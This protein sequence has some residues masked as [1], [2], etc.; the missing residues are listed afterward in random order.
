[1]ILHRASSR[2]CFPSSLLL[3][4]PTAP[5]PCLSSSLLR[6]LHRPHALTP[7]HNPTLDRLTLLSLL[8]ELCTLL[9]PTQFHRVAR[10]PS[11]PPSREAE[12]GTV[13]D[14][15]VT[16]ELVEEFRVPQDRSRKQ[17]IEVG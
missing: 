12:L 9:H 4:V 8:L 15:G 2:S 17:V 14:G 3:V 6:L 7:G 1:M 5:R 10:P 13:R 11:P 16:A